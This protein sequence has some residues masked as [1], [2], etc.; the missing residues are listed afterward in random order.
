MAQLR[1]SKWKRN[2]R[3]PYNWGSVTGFI[4]G[5]YRL[6][7]HGLG[8]KHIPDSLRALPAIELLDLLDNDIEELPT[9]IGELSTLKGLGL[10]GNKLRTLPDEVGSLRNLKLLWLLWNQLEEL[11]ETL[12]SLPL[13]QITLDGN[14][15]L[16]LPESILLQFAV[17]AHM[18][19]LK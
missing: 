15:K 11:P 8:L 19:V 14:P 2:D 17:S 1:I 3:E 6:D 18:S 10:T 4:A 7:P 12:R 16:D 13:E 5:G 9:W